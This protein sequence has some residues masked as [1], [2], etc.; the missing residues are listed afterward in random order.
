[1]AAEQ[2]VTSP[3]LDGVD[4]SGARGVISIGQPQ[5][6][7]RARPTVDQHDQGVLRR[8]R[9]HHPRHEVFDE[10]MDDHLRVTVVATGIGKR[11]KPVL[12]QRVGQGV[13]APIEP[14]QQPVQHV[15]S[16]PAQAVA[17]GGGAAEPAGSTST[18]NRLSGARRAARPPARSRPW[19]RRASSVSTFPPSCAGRPA[20]RL[21]FQ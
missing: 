6:K 14:Q 3:L 5:P 12:V 15:E 8:R 20:D 17:V 16:I 10:D 7:L 11:A 4:L 13:R 2:A 18:I 1:M 9:D 21:V 19:R